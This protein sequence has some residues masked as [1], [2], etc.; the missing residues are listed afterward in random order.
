MNPIEAAPVVLYQAAMLVRAGSWTSVCEVLEAAGATI[1]EL[2]PASSRARR[3]DVSMPEP[4]ET[5][6]EK[7][8][9]KLRETQILEG[10][11]LGKSANEIAAE[12]FITYNTVKTHTRGLFAKLEVGDR[13]HAVAIGYQL[14][15]LGG[16]PR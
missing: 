9:L 4:V 10:L 11:A 15:L 7:P 5:A 2:P 8:F 16:D 6:P 12:L 3:Y 14:G 13:A 1:E